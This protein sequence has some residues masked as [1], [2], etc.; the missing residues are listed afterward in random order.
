MAFPIAIPLAISAI[1]ALLKFRGQVDVILSL[2]EAAA[3]LPFALPPA[4]NDIGAHRERMLSF[5]QTAQ[6]QSILEL[7][8]Q[9]EDF[10]KVLA[11]PTAPSVQ[12]PLNRLFKLYCEA[13]DTQL[14]ILGPQSPTPAAA[15][16]GPSTEMRLAYYV[17]ES[18][19]LSRNPAITRILLAT[20]DMLLDVAGENA[21]L[22]LS[23]PRTREL[24]QLILAEFAAKSD[25]DDD[26]IDRIFKKLLGVTIVAARDN[27]GGIQEKP[28][29]K[30]LFAALREVRAQLGDDFVAEVISVDGFEAL[31]STYLTHVPEDP[32]FLTKDD[33]AQQVITATL[34]EIGQHLPQLT[35][36][37]KALLGVLEVGL[38][39]A[40]ANVEGIL[41]QTLAGKPLLAALLKALGEE[42][43]KRSQADQLF[44][45][46]AHGELIPSLYKA[47]LRAI[48]VNPQL[49][50]REDTTQSFLALLISGL[51]EALAQ[52]EISDLFSLPAL[53][54]LAR[55]SLDVLSAHPL[56]LG[57]GHAFAMHMLA[58]V[59]A[60]GA[61]AVA[62]GLAI[63]DLLAV[64][65]AALKAASEQRALIELSD[66]PVAV[67][68]S[69][70]GGLAADE[71]RRRLTP[72]DRKDLLISAIQ[73][74]ATNPMVWRGL[75]EKDLLQPLVQG[76]L[77]G[78]ATDPSG[79]LSGPAWVD[80]MH[81]VLTA[82]A[83]RG[84]RFIA[85]EVGV[86]DLTRLITLA[87]KRVEQEVGWT[88]DG[89]N[90]PGFLARVV[91]AYL[92][93]P[94]PIARG[95]ECRVGALINSVLTQL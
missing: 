85:A 50:A 68:T 17:V 40:A 67:L 12:G 45:S 90:L 78:L 6:G 92:L 54:L 32:S 82:A 79:L 71:L 3:D 87:L 2:K 74:V 7:K 35:S 31:L 5:F 24:V 95:G 46:I 56:L 21:G 37:P 4:P 20:A 1:K 73:A 91:S 38:T 47:S 49:I 84:K 18:H 58:A 11:N 39:A 44:E 77:Q 80:A 75:H 86:D 61:P 93:A 55:K 89:E 65:Q 69:V 15:I 34:I 8:G 63:D 83:R 27:P 19:R 43:A 64:A 33:L 51:A 41:N 22:F 88:I 57:R 70:G 30:P 72:T 81:A 60:A 28:A 9:H 59:F 42:V 16:S 26:G 66:V 36:D 13:T 76:I 25:F 23:H 29:I 53:H 62:D 94:F 52:Q 48:A 14:A 10:A